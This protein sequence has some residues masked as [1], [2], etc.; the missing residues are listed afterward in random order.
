MV[1]V[2]QI[3]EDGINKP[4]SDSH[5]VSKWALSRKYV[6]SPINGV[7]QYHRLG[8]HERKDPA[9]PYEKASL[10]IS[11][12]SLTIT[13]VLEN[14][15]VYYLVC[16]FSFLINTY[17]FFLQG[18]YHDW[19]KLFEVVS[20]YKTYVEVSHLR[21]LVQVSQNP[22]LWW[23]YAAQA[24]LQQKKMWYLVIFDIFIN[25]K[26]SVVVEKQKIVQ[27]KIGQRSI[28][29]CHSFVI[30]VLLNMKNPRAIVLVPILF[31]N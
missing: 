14:Y 13:E 4:A 27:K 19:I 24:G 6:V 28:L 5:A 17:L 8:N 30:V 2:S 26:V 11:D 16:S 18:Q 1:H 12:V 21:P 20:R 31:V 7:L 25:T 15:F 29:L 22:H 23:Q 10:V 9:I 3:F